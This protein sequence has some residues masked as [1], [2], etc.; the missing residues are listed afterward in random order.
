MNVSTPS[1]QDLIDWL[2]S[3][4]HR[5]E[6]WEVATTKTGALVLRQSPHAH[7][8]SPEEAISSAMHDESLARVQNRHPN[9]T[10]LPA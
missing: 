5:G 7:A 8:R 10:T 6:G 9:Y 2:K 4:S 3:R 1:T